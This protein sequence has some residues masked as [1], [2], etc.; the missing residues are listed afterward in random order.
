MRSGQIR[1]DPDPGGPGGAYPG[2]ICP[3]SLLRSTLFGS[4]G[5][6]VHCDIW[7]WP[8]ARAS[9]PSK[10]GHG[11]MAGRAL[12]IFLFFLAQPP[13]PVFWEAAAH[14]PQPISVSSPVYFASPSS[15]PHRAVFVSIAASASGPAPIIIAVRFFTVQRLLLLAA[16]VVTALVVAAVA[17]LLAVRGAPPSRL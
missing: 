17:L 1:A 13:G 16:L 9:G 12:Q 2:R 3:L 11:S 8:T 5:Y 14:Q 6:R 4:I 10:K 15:S 7:P